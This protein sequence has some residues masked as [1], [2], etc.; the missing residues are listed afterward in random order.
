M[1]EVRRY[2]PGKS[3]RTCWPAEVMVTDAVVREKVTSLGIPLASVT[4]C[5]PAGTETNWNPP[6]APVAVD[7]AAAPVSDTSTPGNGAPSTVTWPMTVPVGAGGGGAG[8]TVPPSPP[9][10]AARS[11]ASTPAGNP[12]SLIYDLRYRRARRSA[13]RPCVFRRP[14]CITSPV[15]SHKVYIRTSSRPGARGLYG[16]DVVPVGVTLA[17]WRAPSPGGWPHPRPGAPWPARG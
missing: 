4:V 10:L 11:P 2:S 17:E 9:Q 16:G 8:S 13:K 12:R 15:S 1:E 7:W 3:A 5:D 14:D 6:S